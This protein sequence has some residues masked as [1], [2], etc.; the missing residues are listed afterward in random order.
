MS[1]ISPATQPS[2]SCNV[3]TGVSIGLTTLVPGGSFKCVQPLARVAVSKGSTL[4]PTLA[5]ASLP[6]TL[7]P[8]PLPNSVTMFVGFAGRGV[9]NCSASKA[10]RNS[11][12]V[13]TRATGS[14]A[15][16]RLPC[17]LVAGERAGMRGGGQPSLPR[18]AALEDDD[19]LGRLR[20]TQ[21]IEK[22]APV[23]DVLEIE[24]DRPCVCGSSR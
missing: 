18:A 5:K 2:F 20:R 24:A 4:S 6:S 15:G 11:S 3:R 13:A 7:E 12:T 17:T 22:G 21:Q 1:R 14:C 9:R 10:S 16:Q 19:R 8:P 23:L